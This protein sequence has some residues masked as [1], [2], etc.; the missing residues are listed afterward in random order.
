[1]FNFK[2]CNVLAMWVSVNKNKKCYWSFWDKWKFNRFNVKSRIEFKAC[3]KIRFKLTF[4]KCFESNACN[5]I[6]LIVFSTTHLIFRSLNSFW[7]DLITVICIKLIC[8]LKS[9]KYVDETIIIN[10]LSLLK[11]IIC[12]LSWRI[13]F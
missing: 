5:F 10:S 8:A 7:V 9:S 4:K 3:W 2:R 12:L 6:R 11:V 13:T 1:M